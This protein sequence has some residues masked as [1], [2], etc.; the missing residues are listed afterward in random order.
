MFVWLYV[1]I[2][3]ELTESGITDIRCGC[4]VVVSRV[5]HPTN[6]Y[7]TTFQSV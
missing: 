7:N 4:G 5:R 6:I 1:V 3:I 2:V